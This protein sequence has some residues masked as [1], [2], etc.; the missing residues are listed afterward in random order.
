ME[1]NC[2]SQAKIVWMC[3]FAA[4]FALFLSVS[5]HATTTAE[6]WQEWGYNNAGTQNRL[7]DSVSHGNT[8]LTSYTQ[9]SY[10][11]THQPLIG[12]FDFNGVPEIVIQDASYLLV[13]N[14]TWGLLAQE[15]I[16][17]TGQPTNIHSS[18]LDNNGLQSFESYM[19]VHNNTDIFIYDFNGSNLDQIYSLNVTASQNITLGNNGFK[20]FYEGTFEEEFCISK[21]L[22]Y[23]N[24][25]DA[26]DEANRTNGGFMTIR[27]PA[28]CHN[29]T[30]FVYSYWDWF[31]LNHTMA[32]IPN[33]YDIDNNG[34]KEA[35]FWSDYDQNDNPGISIFNT[36]AQARYLFIDNVTGLATNPEDGGKS[37]P[38]MYDLNPGGHGEIYF[39]A[40]ASSGSIVKM[41]GYDT[42]GSALS[43]FP[44][45]IGIGTNEAWNDWASPAILKY[46]GSEVLGYATTRF[47][48]P[49]Y[50]KTLGIVD[51]SGTKEIWY[52]PTSSPNYVSYVTASDFDNDGND[53]LIAR[54]NITGY[55]NKSVYEMPSDFP[56]WIIPVD[57]DLDSY[58]DLV[59]C[60][61]S[62]C[63]SLL[64]AGANIGATI[65]QISSNTGSP[66]CIGETVRFTVTDYTD[67]EFNQIHLR[68]DCYGNGTFQSWSTASFAPTQSCNFSAYGSFEVEFQITDS[69][70]YPTQTDS[71]VVTWQVDAG[72]C[73]ESGEGGGDLLG[74]SAN[75]T[76]LNDYWINET[77]LNLNA[78]GGAYTPKYFGW[79]Q[80]GC[81][82][83]GMW[84]GICPLW[85]W[86][87]VAATNVWDKIF[88]AFAIFLTI[89]LFIVLIAF[90]FKHREQIM[91]R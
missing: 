83:W 29:T 42:V 12:D 77:A 67:P 78:T 72:N 86:I 69:A 91:P 20:C 56:Y 57:L 39:I 28:T 79:A 85:K 58:L 54:Y 88:A 13:Y 87:A 71:E 34:V 50:T 23:R 62:A 27:I 41:F 33:F 90:F 45:S 26:I 81:A 1:K 55:N 9:G 46:N 36:V 22:R 68:I 75:V 89:L 16:S 40:F 15:T 65:N 52:A 38:I 35:I 19:L 5:S 31:D 49:S 14:S 32:T 63:W 30:C 60:G 18:D 3:A 21:Y 53:D 7:G 61:S 4:V 59:A 64:S 11:T 66:S 6:L 70:N 76:G 17:L 10:G 24:S 47:F 37:Q 8:N 2:K 48:S 80:S 73:Y 25:S 43:G 51:S 74:V 84:K 82:T 44:E